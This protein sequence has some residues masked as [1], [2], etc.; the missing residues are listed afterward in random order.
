MIGLGP[1]T[2]VVRLLRPGWS[3][4][5]LPWTRRELRLLRRKY[6]ST[7]TSELAHELQ[8]PLSGVHRKAAAL[9]LRKSDEFL[10]TAASGRLQRG[11][12]LGI[13]GRFQ[14]GHVPAN[15][16][17]RRPGWAPGRMRETQFKKGQSC[18]AANENWVPIGTEVL[19]HDGYLKR[20]VSDDPT[21]ASRFNW[22][23]VHVLEWERAN[24]RP[25][26]A[27]H[28]VVFR[29]GDKTDIRPENLELLN[30]RELMA[31]NTVHNL[32]PELVEVVRLKG[33]LQRQI[34]KRARA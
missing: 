10:S 29:N 19:D 20:K 17:L 27:E 3:A 15:K 14:K 21:L 9:G 12:S 31:R 11:S 6:P 22:R 16:G 24:G 7:L 26:P 32:P 28:A 2:I 13:S 33:V 34:N 8:R 30:R 23:Y 5:R 1:V 25:V 4:S 18:G